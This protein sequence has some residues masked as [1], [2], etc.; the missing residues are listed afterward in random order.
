MR[1]FGEGGISMDICL[2][3]GRSSGREMFQTGNSKCKGPDADKTFAFPELQ[4]KMNM[5]R[6][7]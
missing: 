2:K 1:L 3:E 4:I 5:T 7:E 6:V